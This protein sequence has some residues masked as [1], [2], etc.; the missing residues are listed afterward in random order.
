MAWAGGGWECLCSGFGNL[1]FSVDPLLHE[2][3]P[4]R[5]IW[6]MTESSVPLSKPG[7][8][9]ELLHFKG[10]FLIKARLPMHLKSLISRVVPIGLP[11]NPNNLLK[12]RASPHTAPPQ[13]SEPL[14]LSP[15]L[16]PSAL[17]P[18]QVTLKLKHRT[19]VHD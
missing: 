7:G 10:L 15:I 13:F 4:N 11:K 18:E 12:P 16:K 19:L 17:G 3:E 9:N 5:V 6:E 2:Q 8:L 1:P 14:A